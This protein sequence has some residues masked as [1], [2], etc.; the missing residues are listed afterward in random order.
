MPDHPTLQRLQAILD[1][2]NGRLAVLAATPYLTAATVDRAVH[3][4]LLDLAVQCLALLQEEPPH[5]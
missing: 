5:A 1:D 2:L 3:T 4:I